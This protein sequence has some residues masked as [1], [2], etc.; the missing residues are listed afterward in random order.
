MILHV[1][2]QTSL[3]GRRF[4]KS[5]LLVWGRIAGSS[6]PRISAMFQRSKSESRESH[7]RHMSNV[8]KKLTHQSLIAFPPLSFTEADLSALGESCVGARLVDVRRLV[9]SS[10]GDECRGLDSVEGPRQL[11]VAFCC[12]Y[13]RQRGQ[14]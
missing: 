2:E 11:V 5:F 3:A 12:R 13:R 7:M 14:R 8:G 6:S 4:K 1:R 9:S 10:K